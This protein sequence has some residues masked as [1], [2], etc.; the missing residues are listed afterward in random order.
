MN[1]WLGRIMLACWFLCFLSLSESLGTCAGQ[2]AEGPHPPQQEAE[3]FHL[4][5]CQRLFETCKL[6]PCLQLEVPL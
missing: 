6:S 3:V 2:P 5:E 4:R 1:Q